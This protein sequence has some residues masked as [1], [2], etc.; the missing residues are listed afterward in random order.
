MSTFQ[1][2]TPKPTAQVREL[3]AI[4]PHSGKMAYRTFV[5]ALKETYNKDA[6]DFLEL[7]ENPKGG[8]SQTDNKFSSKE[9]DKSKDETGDVQKAETVTSSGPG[10]TRKQLESSN[11]NTNNNPGN[12][13]Q[14][15]HPGYHSLI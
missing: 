15:N 12:H 7:K 1:H 4:L 5:D 10:T 8:S 2:K 6:A 14:S 11:Q 13:F 9:P 3:L